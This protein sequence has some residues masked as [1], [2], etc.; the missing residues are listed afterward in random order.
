MSAVAMPIAKPQKKLTFAEEV[1]VIQLPDRRLK[2]PQDE[3]TKT[4]GCFFSRPR[5]SR[6]YM[7]GAAIL[8]Q[9]GGNKKSN[10]KTERKHE[11]KIAPEPASGKTVTE[12]NRDT[13]ATLQCTTD[14]RASICQKVKDAPCVKTDPTDKATRA[15]LAEAA[16]AL[17]ALNRWME[18][19]GLS[20]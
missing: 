3:V 19:R 12:R 11:R 20:I 9:R 16:V 7:D 10:G 18:A 4:F 14:T 17:N 1:K 8:Q 5:V 6:D 13:D 15:I 2:M